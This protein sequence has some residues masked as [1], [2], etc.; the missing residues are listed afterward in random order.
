MGTKLNIK[1]GDT[2]KVIAGNSKGE[3]GRVLQVIPD[4]M[5]VLVEGVNLR[6]KATRP[7]QKHPNGGIIKIEAPVH[8]S[9][10]ML[11][12]KEG[13]PTR[14]RRERS[15]VNGKTIIKR[16]AVTTGEEL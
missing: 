12:D 1:K 9:N 16:L 4:K 11:V 8:Y 5:M 6:S 7:S 3:V 2:V 14:I 10:V 15:T 13:K